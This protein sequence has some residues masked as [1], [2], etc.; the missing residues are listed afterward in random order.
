MWS[1]KWGNIQN[2]AS[3]YPG[4]AKVDVTPSMVKQVGKFTDTA[5]N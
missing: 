4:K 5:L 2:I 3:P 1:Q